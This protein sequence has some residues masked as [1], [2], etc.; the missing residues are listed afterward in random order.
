MGL[1]GRVVDFY[2]ALARLDRDALRL[3]AV[4]LVISR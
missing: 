3:R 2:R 1:R 4:D